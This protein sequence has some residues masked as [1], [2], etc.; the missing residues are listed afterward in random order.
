MS[1]RLSV[2]KKNRKGILSSPPTK[3]DATETA[4]EKT[5]TTCTATASVGV[6]ANQRDD[7]PDNSDD[8]CPVCNDAVNN[9]S[10]KCD[11]SDHRIHRNCTGLHD[12][13]FDKTT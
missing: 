10:A 12:E 5:T 2:M 1:L 3:P 13:V 6:S 4:A 11:I 7:C 8:I 9:D